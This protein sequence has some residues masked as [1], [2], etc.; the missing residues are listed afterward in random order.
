LSLPAG[1]PSCGLQILG[2]PHGEEALLRVG[3]AVEK[4]LA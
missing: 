2:K 3:A 1:A 4:A